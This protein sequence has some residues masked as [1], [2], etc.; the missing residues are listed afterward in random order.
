MPA[1]EAPAPPREHVP[2]EAVVPMRFRTPYGELALFSKVATFGAPADVTLSELA[3]ERFFPLDEPTTRVLRAQADAPIRPGGAADLPA[4][5]FSP[6]PNV[7]M[8][9]APS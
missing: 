4:G 5:P 3:I 1:G 8:R 9:H 6:K 2:R 7:R